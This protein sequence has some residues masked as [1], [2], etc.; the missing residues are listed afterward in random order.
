M[1]PSLELLR[2]R[3]DGD[4]TLQANTKQASLLKFF[5]PVSK[6]G[7]LLFYYQQTDWKYFHR[8]TVHV[9]YKAIVIISSKKELC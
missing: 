3:G 5:S 7:L 6:L 9:M 1:L 8:D 2:K 4:S